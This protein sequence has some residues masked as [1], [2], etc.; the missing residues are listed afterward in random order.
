MSDL[1]SDERN[2]QRDSMGRQAFVLR[3]FALAYETQVLEAI[4]TIRKQAPF[5]HMVTPGGRTMSVMVTNCGDFG[6][7]TSSAGYRYSKI[8]PSS[9][10]PW[11]AM[12]PILRSI[13][14]EAA[15]A[16]GFE[17]YDPDA[18]AINLYKPES[19]LTL[20]QD[21]NEHDFDAPI[22][23][24]SLG[25]TANFLFGGLDRSDRTHK[26]LLFHG[27]VAGWGGE[28]RLRFHGVQSLVEVPHPDIGAYRLSVTFRKAGA[29]FT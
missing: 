16:M 26:Y 3:G 25:M 17:D 28:D 8:D 21:K 12:P 9:G 29:P 5:R 23:T 2:G 18:C 15:K 14:A 27:D 19:R 11:P 10:S 6:W 7:T 20:H 24:I 4:R 13:A 1:F 22:I